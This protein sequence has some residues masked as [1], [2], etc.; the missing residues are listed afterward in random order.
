MTDPITIITVMRDEGPFILEWIAWNRMIGVDHF[1][2]FTNGCSDGTDA[3]LD[4]L[5]DMGIVTHLPN[6]VEIMDEGAPHRVALKYAPLLKEYRRSGWIFHSDVDEFLHI[7]VGNGRLPDLIDACGDPDAISICETLVGCSGVE[8]FVD[9]PITGQF[10]RSASMAPA[11]DKQR[12]GV[13]T[14]FKNKDIWRGRH[15]HRPVLRRSDWGT[16]RWADGSGAPVPQ[17]F[18]QGREPGLDSI[19]RFDLAV[20]N[21]YS[22]RSME[23]YLCKL[24]RG[25]A[26]KTKRTQGGKYWRK[27]NQNTQDNQ[28]MLPHQADLAAAI[29]ELKGDA[30]LAHLH[31][32][33]VSWHQ[34]QIEQAKADPEAAELIAFFRSTLNG[35]DRFAI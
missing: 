33:A 17:D 14:L 20:L 15:N 19:G 18:R 10:T 23:S 22:I 8:A 2:V 28:L 7:S 27:R 25:D 3:M 16:A 29:A 11:P 9:A 5:D 6:P 1:I 12:R 21:H 26:V 34:A 32:Q 30:T 24:A 35:I 4:R 31:N 13:K